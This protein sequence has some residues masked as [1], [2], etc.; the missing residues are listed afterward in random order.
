MT[1]AICGAPADGEGDHGPY[2]PDPDDRD[3]QQ[4]EQDAGEG[5]QQIDDTRPPSLSSTAEEQGQHAQSTPNKKALKLT[6]AARTRDRRVAT[7]VRENMSR[8][9]SSV[10]NGCA[11]DERSA[12]A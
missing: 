2:A 6:A 8:P 10:P 1:R 5:A 9:S 11:A 4:G 3:H 12:S 7:S